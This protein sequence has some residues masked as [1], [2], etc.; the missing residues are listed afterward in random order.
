MFYS[1][2]SNLLPFYVWRCDCREELCNSLYDLL[3]SRCA[4]P[5]NYCGHEQHRSSDGTLLRTF[6]TLSGTQIEAK[7]RRAADT[8]PKFRKLSFAERGAMMNSA[9]ALLKRKKK[10]RPHDDA[11]DGEDAA[12]RRRRS[13]E[14]RLACRYYAENGERIPGRRGGRQR[15]RRSY[16]RYQPIGPVLAVMPWNF[17]FWQVFRFA[18]PGSDGGQRRAVEALVERAAMRAGDRRDPAARGIPGR[19]VSDVADRL[20]R[21]S[22]RVIAD[23]RVAAATLTGSEP[24]GRGRRPG[25]RS[26]SRRPCWNW[27]AAIRSS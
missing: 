22:R 10:S 7:L 12:V 17:P 21:R 8:F 27:A 9:A 25:R 11:G 26:A 15:R 4:G 3:D 20:R 14:V 24:G 2:I 1:R 19:R 18:A 13:G 6:Q 5:Y 23:D 16:V